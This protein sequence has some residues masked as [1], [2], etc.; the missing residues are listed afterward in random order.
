[1][2]KLVVAGAS[3]TLPHCIECKENTTAEKYSN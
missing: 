2:W 3:S 1:M